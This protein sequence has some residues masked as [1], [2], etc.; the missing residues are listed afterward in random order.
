MKN[1]KKCGKEFEPN[2]GK[3]LFCSVNCKVAYFRANGKKEI[4]EEP[5]KT[6]TAINSSEL[7]QW[8]K[9]KLYCS[10]NDLTPDKLILYHDTWTMI[11]ALEKSKIP[12]N[13]D[14][15]LGRIVF[16]NEIKEHI[17]GLLK[18]LK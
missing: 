12:P 1:C 2:H 4:V 14:T 8:N 11:H 3:Q 10:E 7:D 9:V 16:K 18:K 15:T 6:E 5:A 17:D 13:R